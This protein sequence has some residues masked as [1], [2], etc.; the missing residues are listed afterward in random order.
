MGFA[1]AHVH[2]YAPQ[3]HRLFN[4]QILKY[5]RYTGIE[6]LKST[7]AEYGQEVIKTLAQHLHI[8]YG[9]GFTRAGLFRML[10]FYEVFPE[11]KIVATLSRQ[12]N[13]RHIIE[14]LPLKEQNQKDFYA[15]T[16]IQEN[17]SVRQ[18]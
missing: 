7:R 3:A 14:L 17:W 11:E 2:L 18:L 1:F 9:K 16:S 10:Q 13:W 12:L 5:L 6:I 15:Y 8:K 4:F